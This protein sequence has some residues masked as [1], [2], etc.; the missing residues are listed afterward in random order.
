M[1]QSV[2]QNYAGLSGPRFSSLK[3]AVIRK[4]FGY[5][6]V[7]SDIIGSSVDFIKLHH[8][9]PPRSIDHFQDA[10]VSLVTWKVRRKIIFSPVVVPTD[11]PSRR[12]DAPKQLV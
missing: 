5:S 12:L 4:A 2:D 3:K 9:Q 1:G 8:N 6:L 7:S 10:M 11:H